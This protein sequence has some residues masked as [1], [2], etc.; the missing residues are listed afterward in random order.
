MSELSQPLSCG[1]TLGRI[2]ER[3]SQGA[4]AAV[5]IEELMPRSREGALSWAR[6]LSGWEEYAPQYTAQAVALARIV[7]RRTMREFSLT[8]RADGRVEEKPREPTPWQT[9]PPTLTF[10]LELAG[11]PV[12]VRYTRR[13]FPDG[14]TDMLYFVS[15]HEIGRP[16]ALSGSGHLSHL[17]PS[18][19]VE[20]CGGPQAYA[21][22]LADAILR[23][24]EKQFT[25]TFEG[26][27]PK[28]GQRQPRKA[29]RPRPTPGG[30]AARVIAEE[31]KAPGPPP[32][33]MLF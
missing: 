22:L 27:F 29:K 26:A 20:A 13:Y 3:L 9:P 14:V 8:L 21:V 23:G 32:P 2:Q 15:P 11:E 1:Q 28:A 16:H 33:G 7:S 19:I 31:E 18:D 24:E 10:L 6:R 17:V 25:E 30:H 12:Q 4:S 5:I